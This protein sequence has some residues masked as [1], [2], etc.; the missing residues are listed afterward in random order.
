MP[1]EEQ[2]ENVFVL[3]WQKI[4]PISPFAIAT[5]RSG[6]IKP[7]IMPI[8][9]TRSNS[10]RSDSIYGLSSVVGVVISVT[11]ITPP[12]MFFKV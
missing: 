11:A 7:A 9:P 8:I 1:P 3:L 12:A 6:T 4:G 5:P 2:I 10:M